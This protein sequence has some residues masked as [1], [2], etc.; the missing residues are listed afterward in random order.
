MFCAS[1][2]FNKKIIHSLIFLIAIAISN[3]LDDDNCI[4]LN[5]LEQIN[6]LTIE[7]TRIILFIQEAL[8]LALFN[9]DSNILFQQFICSIFHEIHTSHFN[10]KINYQ[11]LQENIPFNFNI[12]YY[13]QKHLLFNTEKLLIPFA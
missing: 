4:V 5:G 6:H 12:L 9:I 8:L 1:K 3:I 10:I 2:Y 11:H 7:F 13:F